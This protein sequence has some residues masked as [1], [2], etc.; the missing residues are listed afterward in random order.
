MTTSV[1]ALADAAHRQQFTRE[2]VDLLKRTVAKGA[3][4]DE[5]GLFFNVCQRTGLDP[6]TKQIHAIKRWSQAENRETIAFQ[7]GI[8][9]YRVIA[10]RS[11]EYEGQTAVSWFDGGV[12]SDVW[13]QDV[14]PAAARV[15]VWRKGFREPAYAVA[16]WREYVQTKRDGKPTAMWLK[17]PALMLAKCAEALALRKAFPQELSGIYTHEEMAQADTGEEGQPAKEIAAREVLSPLPFPYPPH[18]GVPLSAKDTEGKFVISV[19]KLQTAAQLI[20]RG[21]SDAPTEKLP[22][23]ERMLSDLTTE[24]QRRESEGPAA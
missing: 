6:F 22:Q 17:M 21:M 19:A 2:Q 12:W 15:G 23:F 1:A 13:V 24:I 8:D 5:L 14:P 7:T 9:G 16:T 20:E 3:N 4:D 10:Q 18:K 11:G